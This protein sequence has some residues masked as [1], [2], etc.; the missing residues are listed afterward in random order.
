MYLYF[1]YRIDAEK[2]EPEANPSTIS[3][4]GAPDPQPTSAQGDDESEPIPIT[5]LQPN[6]K[7][8][9]PITSPPCSAKT[10]EPIPVSTL[11]PNEKPEAPIT[12][13]PCLAKKDIS[14]VPG[15]DFANGM[16][17]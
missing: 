10:D 13:A 8:E 9:R 15:L 11:H 3:Y 2:L 12:S 14:D 6:E 1:L 16:Q 5:T 7:P 17:K 4:F